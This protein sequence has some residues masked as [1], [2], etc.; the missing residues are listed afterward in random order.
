[1]RSLLAKGKIASQD[2]HP[3]RCECICQRNQQRSIAVRACT[4]GQDQPIAPWVVG[5]MQKSSNGLLA[6]L[7]GSAR[8]LFTW[9]AIRS[10]VW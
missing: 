3:D 9:P 6:K 10:M 2:R 1:V 8:Q 4:M 5:M 7:G